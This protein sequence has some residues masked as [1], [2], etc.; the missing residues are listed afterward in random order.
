MPSSWKFFLLTYDVTSHV[1][2]LTNEHLAQSGHSYS[3][4]LISHVYLSQ[5]AAWDFHAKKL[6]IRKNTKKKAVG[7]F[8]KLQECRLKLIPPIVKENKHSNG[9]INFNL[10]SCKNITFYITFVYGNL[11]CSRQCRG[12]IKGINWRVR[13][14]LRVLRE[15]INVVQSTLIIFA[16][17]MLVPLGNF[18]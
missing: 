4:I 3:W 15:S 1:T 2:F 16:T 18:G 5:S 17:C 11:T 14:L 6:Y 12:I 9:G 7:Y 8:R 10:H 13:N